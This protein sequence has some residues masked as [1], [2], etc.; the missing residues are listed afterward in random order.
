MINNFLEE[1]NQSQKN[2]VLNFLGPN[3][4]I[5]GAGSG[6]TKVLT[7]RIAYLISQGV[8]PYQIL[9]LTFTNKASAEMR[10]RIGKLVGKEQ[11]QYIVSGTFHKIFAKILRIEAEKLKYTSN[12]TIYDTTDTKSVIKKIINDLRLDPE[13][14]KPNAVLSRISMAKNNLVTAQVYKNNSQLKTNDRL[15]RM[16]EIYRIYEQYQLRCRQSNAM[17]FDDLLLNINILF[18]DNPEI[19]EKYKKR[20]QFILVD[21]YQDTNLSQYLIIKKLAEDHRNITV[22][23]DDAQSIYSFRGAKIENILNFRN[24]Y[25]DYKLFKLEQNYRSTKM[26]VNAANSLI[27]KN[28][29]QIRKKVFSNND[30]GSKIKVIM[31]NTDVEEG[32]NVAS[33]IFDLTYS[34]NYKYSDFAILYRTNQQSRIFEEALRKRNMPYRLYGGTVFYQRKEIKDMLSYLRVVVNTQDNEAVKRIIN[35]P[36]RG[37]GETTLEKIE[38]IA[39]SENKTI[40]AVITNLHNYGT[41]FNAGTQNKI[42]EFT[43]FINTF[44]HQQNNLNAYDLSLKIAQDAGILKDLFLDKSPEGISHYE[45]IKELLNGIKE[46][47]E[48]ELEDNPENP[49]KLENYLEN[50]ALLTDADKNDTNSD[51]ISLMTVHSAKGLEFSN[52]YI[53]GVEQDLFPSQMASNSAKDIEEE[54]RLFYVAITRAKENA[55]ITY[56]TSRRKWGN[57]T[58]CNPSIFISEINPEFIDLPRN[59]INFKTNKAQESKFENFNEKKETFSNFSKKTTTFATFK[60]TNNT[61][62]FNSF[63]SDDGSKIEVGMI[64]EHFRFGKGQVV[65]IED[66]WPNSKAEITFPTGKKQL[67]LKFAK[68]KIIKFE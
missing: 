27:E 64:V 7:V 11:A 19:A 6:K 38:N 67:L 31:S 29:E 20:F 47:T 65:S 51:K 61:T 63:S 42:L 39:I 12:F 25:T 40:W 58:F 34:N 59:T 37:I 23:G 56:A 50:V 26:I 16:P 1:L 22:V 8:K 10:E 43:N 32:Y 66:K 18:R 36:K 48:Q 45:N 49:I 41:A 5:A 14:Y 52:V 60:N 68:L 17:D 24:D 2:A 28:K 55:I 3:L 9:A 53:V 4:I 57:F 35:Y 44:I 54:R 46:F 21:E 13:T 62:S 15:S 33:N 30:T